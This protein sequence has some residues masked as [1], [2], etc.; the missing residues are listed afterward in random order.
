M[1]N[2][3]K[4]LINSP[5][6]ENNFSGFLM[7]AL[8]W[9]H[10]RYIIIATFVMAVASII[11]SLLLPNWYSSTASVVPPKNAGNIL[12]QAMGGLS[13]TLK[14]IGLSKLTGGKG[15]DQYDFQVILESRTVKD[16]IIKK[17]K[18]KEAYVPD[19]DDR[20]KARDSEIREEFDDNLDITY[21]SDGNY[22]ITIL[23]KDSTRVA[24]MVNDYIYYTNE[25]AKSLYHSEI[26][27][28]KKYMEGRV[29]SMNVT[30][31]SIADELS[32]VSR[33]TGIISPESQAKAYVE[34]ISDLKSQAMLQ[35]VYLDLFKNKYGEKD[36]MTL[37]QQDIVSSLNKKMRDA[38][39]K[40]G[41]VGNFTPSDATEKGIRYMKLYAEYEAMTKLKL[42]MEP[43]LEEAKLNES[44]ELL[45]LSVVDEPLTPDKKSKPKRSLIVA[46]A[47]LGGTFVSILVILF[48]YGIRSFK[49]HYNAVINEVNA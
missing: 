37:N 14:E 31:D 22:T 49:R 15:G 9:K 25:L 44:R 45:S 5:Q 4:S 28:N 39:T 38:E 43:M 24:A 36:Q 27:F 41:L 35:S 26:G 48:I 13:S 21:E 29:A 8:L 47:T 11:Y 7:V 2:E 1:D 42:L 33:E 3:Q 30:L 23:D 16:S 34:A 20:K 40:P 32:R 10:K 17:Y 18:L 19:P 6:S 46:G 12:D